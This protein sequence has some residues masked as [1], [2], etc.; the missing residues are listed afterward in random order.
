L[1]TQWLEEA[2][3]PESVSARSTILGQLG[4][5]PVKRLLEGQT[6]LAVIIA[7]KDNAKAQVAEADDKVQGDVATA[8]YFGCIASALVRHGQQVSSLSYHELV[9]AFSALIQKDWM[10]PQL[11]A[12]LEEAR[13]LCEQREASE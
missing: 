3:A 13:K 4:H 8:I 12:L 11:K 7:L 1:L 9:S 6:D 5:I 2:L 10:H